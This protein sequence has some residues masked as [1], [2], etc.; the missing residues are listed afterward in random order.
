MS[1]RLR[2]ILCLSATAA[3]A[4]GVS[5]G[6]AA[7]AFAEEVQPAAKDQV[8]VDIVGDSYNS[9]EG[10]RGTYF[11]P[12]DRRHR[13]PYASGS[14]A[15]QRLQDANPD[16]DLDGQTGAS[17]G[18]TTRDVFE[19]QTDDDGNVIN[20]PQGSLVRPDADA[21]VM[22]F[23]G[24]DALFADV[25]TE[26]WH[27]V[28]N[29]QSSPRFDEF[30]AGL[31][32]LMDT[33]LTPEEYARQAET[34][35]GGQA[36]TI[37]A[38]ML[39]AMREIQAKA[40]G[41]KLVVPNYPLPVDPQ[42]TSV[43]SRFSEYELERFRAFGTQLNQAI[44][45]SVELC[46]CAT[47]ADM[48][49]ALDG[50]EAYTD[51]PAINDLN[52]ALT[53]RY[54]Q[55]NSMEP[56]H[57]NV[58]GGGLMSDAIARALAEAL[59]LKSPEPGGAHP[60]PFGE[61]R[62]A[63]DPE[64]FDPVTRGQTEDD[65]DQPDADDADGKKSDSDAK[66]DGKGKGHDDGKN[67]DDGSDEPGTEN[68]GTDDPG[69]G[70]DDPGTTDPGT[71]EQDPGT[72]PGT[73]D[74]ATDPSTT[75]DGTPTT[76]EDPAPTPISATP[77][78]APIE[79]PVVPPTSGDPSTPSHEGGNGG[80]P[81]P[82][83]PPADSAPPADA[84]PP[85]DS[86]PPADTAPPADSTPPADSNDDGN[87]FDGGGWNSET[88][89]NS[90]GSPDDRDED[91]NDPS[92]ISFGGGGGDGGSH[93]PST[94]TDGSSPDNGGAPANSSG[95]PD[96]RDGTSGDAPGGGFGDS[97]GGSDNDSSNHDTGAPANSSGSPDDRDGTSGDGSYGGDDSGS[98][99]SGN[100]SSNHDTGAPANS[101]GSPDDRDSTS[102]DSLGGGYSDSYGDGNG[103]CAC[104]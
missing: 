45:K 26:A 62:E 27:S 44:A 102:G 33:T 54:D 82:S 19:P 41:A 42:A 78:P 25:L 89:A 40:P 96:D 32:P 104:W 14:Q 60:T 71:G 63:P 7:P 65:E 37:V 20:P 74:P 76:G 91:S 18:A 97:F 13:S 67:D 73:S 2:R 51:D 15:L 24:N 43:W 101:S 29:G 52:A 81:A 49:G 75:P 64:G 12:E 95:S 48:A 3:V 4:M 79:G 9:G 59:G 66:G 68:P 92:G 6:L 86:A 103:S 10:M 70:T 35:A 98:Y 38:R 30:M 21:V 100:D 22:G 34:T 72:N 53:G 28:T 47:L 88:P 55:W 56:F 94:G 80:D 23:G 36:P 61:L 58:E 39:Q 77:D 16:V 46:G 17:S 87:P 57:P 5:V 8:N 1:L 11:D 85:A 90:S 93:D 99:G 69:T 50:R 31:A 84:A 83:T